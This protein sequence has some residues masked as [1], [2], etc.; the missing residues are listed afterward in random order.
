LLAFPWA[1]KL[2]REHGRVGYNMSM[3]DKRLRSRI[4]DEAAR[5]LHQKDEQ[6]FI[7]A[8]RK[9]ARLLGFRFKP[10]DLPSNRE[11]SHR[12]ERM[13]A[14]TGPPIRLPT[15]R[16]LAVEGLRWLRRFETYSP[17]LGWPIKEPG[18]AE[19]FIEVHLTR[20]TTDAGSRNTST[21]VG[22]VG[23][24]ESN[25]VGG[26]DGVVIHSDETTA[27]NPPTRRSATTSPT[28]G[29]VIFES[30]LTEFRKDRLDYEVQ[31][32]RGGLGGKR[33]IPI[34]VR[35]RWPIRFFL[36]SLP[37]NTENSL[38]RTQ[39]ETELL[40]ERPSADLE[41]E[42]LGLHD[43]SERLEYFRLLLLQLEE[44][45][46]LDETAGD[47]L[48]RALQAFDLAVGERPYDEEF[49]TAALLHDVGRIGEDENESA[50]DLLAGV[51]T[52]RTLWLIQNLDDESITAAAAPSDDDWR[53]LQ[54]LRDLVKKSGVPGAE[55]RS[56]EEALGELA[57]F[58]E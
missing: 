26:D 4:A 10:R 35:S 20:L 51:V 31:Q 21:L 15:K 23:S 27:S 8:K 5:L 16:Q 46:P 52:N 57:R 56:L 9:A 12:L 13:E 19:A 29:E 48:H 34:L 49:L 7:R 1:S 55:T 54:L 39:L 3:G 36:Y 22:E 37:L 14:E 38:D 2:A 18:S 41:A 50:E 28:R 17:R 33:G 53:D 32:E 43:G 11:I 42:L 45:Q 47:L 6:E 25:R 44:M 58:E 24:T 40:R 30:V